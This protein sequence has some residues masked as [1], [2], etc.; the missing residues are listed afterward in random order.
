[1]SNFQWIFALTVAA[2][3]TSRSG[4][5]AATGD[6]TNAAAFSALCG[7]YNA[8]TAPQTV[9]DVG[10]QLNALAADVGALN[11]SAAAPEFQALFDP[12]DPKT[13]AKHPSRPSAPADAVASWDM[14]YDFW[15]KSKQQMEANEKQ[16][17]LKAAIGLP[18]SAKVQLKELAEAAFKLPTAPE[19]T[20]PK[21]KQQEFVEAANTAIYGGDPTTTSAGGGHA[22]DRQAE[23]GKTDG[24][25]GTLSGKTLRNDFLCVCAA[26]SEAQTKAKTCC[27]ACAAPGGTQW[28][29]PE[30][31]AKIFDHLKEHCST[32]ATEDQATPSAINGAIKGLITQ[33]SQNQGTNNAVQFVLGTIETSLTAGCCGQSSANGGMCV[34][35]KDGTTKKAVIDWLRPAQTAAAALPALTAANKEAETL[36]AKAEHLNA[37]AYTAMETALGIAIAKTNVIVSHKA[38]NSDCSQH[39]KNQSECEKADNNCKWEGKN[40]TEGTCKPKDGG[41][42]DKQTNTAGGAGDATKEGT[43]A[44]TGCASHGIKADCENDKTGDKQ[45]CAWRKGKEGETDEPDKFAALLF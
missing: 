7:V 4:E 44:S 2:L 6:L 41:K 39:S 15:L 12:K 5:A 17:R 19:L 9:V 1:M 8:L 20:K 45:N 27:D 42:A 14:Y 26:S 30:N 13:K 36:L 40:E 24:N 21:E 35:Y 3:G 29:N 16:R 43:A 33:A 22:N 25:K 37:T 34:S 23:C 31:G 11:M 28:T 18:P 38:T 32:F 10:G